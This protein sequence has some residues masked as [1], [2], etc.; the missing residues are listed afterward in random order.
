MKI[1]KH[2][3]AASSKITVTN[4]ATGVYSLIN[5]AGSVTDTQSRFTAL[6]ANALLITPEDGDIRL[7]FGYT[8][9]ST[10]GML[11]SSGTKYFIPNLDDGVQ[12]VKL[13]RT[14]GSN[15]A[16]SVEVCKAVP[17]ETGWAVA[18][19]VSFDAGI[20]LTVD[21]ELAAAAALSDNFANPTTAPLGAMGMVYDGSTWDRMRG[22]STDGTLVNLGT[23]NDVTVT[24][25]T[26]TANAGTNLNTSALALETGGNLAT[27][28]GDTT[29]IDGK[30]TACDT[31]SIAG[32]VTAN[33]GTNLNTSALALETGGN[34]ATIAGDTT[35]IDGKITACDTG[36][37]AGTVTANAGTNLNTSALALETGGNLATIAGDTTSIDGKITACNTGAVVISTLPGSLQGPGNPTVD[38]YQGVNISAVT[39]ANQQIVAAPGASKQIWVYG[40]SFTCDTDATTVAFQDEDDTAHAT[41]GEGFKQY[42]GVNIPP[43]GNFAM[44]LF[45]VATNKALEADVAVGTIGGELHYAVVSV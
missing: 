31:G 13:I 22:D 6:G 27:I 43:S 8:P 1:L 15:V 40:Y 42:G 29:S 26:V 38:S 33:A 3:N 45:K 9:T 23:N 14:G 44:P 12:D 16:V 25:G 21:T 32:T 35:S 37:I 36:S 19:S 5:T 7:G 34:L 11:L 17:G 18:E 28:A 4:T 24:S 20:S 39:G 10:V 2:Q 41:Y 30:I